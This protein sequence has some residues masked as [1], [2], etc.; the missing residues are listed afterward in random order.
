MERRHFV[1]QEKCDGVSG[2][3]RECFG[4]GFNTR[5]RFPQHNERRRCVGSVTGDIHCFAVDRNT[6]ARKRAPRVGFARVGCCYNHQRRRINF[7]EYGAQ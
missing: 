1:R 6:E 2:M 7:I 5:W 3:A 4:N